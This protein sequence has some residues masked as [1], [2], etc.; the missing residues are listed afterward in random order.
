[1]HL[2]HGHRNKPR[3]V[4]C[5]SA[6]HV[7][8]EWQTK[9]GSGF[10]QLS[11][12]PWAIAIGL[13]YSAFFFL[14]YFCFS[15]QQPGSETWK[16]PPLAVLLVYSNHIFNGPCLSPMR[17]CIA[18]KEVWSKSIARLAISIW[19]S[20]SN[21]EVGGLWILLSLISLEASPRECHP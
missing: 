8:R 19:H 21:G 6:G 12:L 10:P 1:M 16:Q 3:G 9:W 13:S 5:L 20:S 2:F 14:S 17:V 15:V 11:L 4:T 7:A 18:L